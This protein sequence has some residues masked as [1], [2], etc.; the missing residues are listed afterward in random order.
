VD[1][2]I[3]D[4]QDIATRCYTYVSTLRLVL[5]AAAENSIPVIVADRP[6]PLPDAVDGVSRR[7]TLDGVTVSLDTFDLFRGRFGGGFWGLQGGCRGRLVA[8]QDPV[9]WGAA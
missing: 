3:F 1:V 9:G 6:I 5:E 7:P 2:L 8:A 4:I